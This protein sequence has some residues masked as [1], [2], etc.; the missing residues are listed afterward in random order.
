MNKLFALAMIV[1]SST[2][3]ATDLDKT[4]P[5][6]TI[7][8]FMLEHTNGNVTITGTADSVIRITT[9]KVRGDNACYTAIDQD[10]TVLDLQTARLDLMIEPCEVN[11]TIALPKTMA[12]EAIVG[13]GNITVQ[14]M[15][16]NINVTM[17]A[18]T[19]TARG[20]FP[21]ALF[22]LGIGKL[23]ATWETLPKPGAVT[24]DVGQGEVILNFPKGSAISTELNPG[25]ATVATQVN[26]TSSASFNVFGTMRGGKILIQ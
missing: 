20:N 3:I 17:S 8:V 18:G 14:N 22:E 16:G 10:D 19:L 6:G 15:T 7:T 13:S 5:A 12:I 21:L 4:I 26:D 25:R 2:A 1:F 11:A 23:D 24:F 9:H